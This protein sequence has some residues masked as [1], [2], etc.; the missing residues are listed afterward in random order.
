[1]MNDFG[2]AIE[3]FCRYV[4][5]KKNSAAKEPNIT[6]INR[7]GAAPH[8]VLLLLLLCNPFRGMGA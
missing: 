6:N 7:K 5:N 1:M 8:V 4:E 2:E 3:A